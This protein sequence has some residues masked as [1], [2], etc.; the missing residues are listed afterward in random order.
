M[1]FT[2]RECFKKYCPW[3]NICETR[4]FPDQKLSSSIFPCCCPS[5]RPTS[6]ASPLI[7]TI[8]YFR[9]YKPFL[10]YFF[11]RISGIPPLT[12]KIEFW[13]VLQF[14]SSNASSTDL[15]HRWTSCEQ[16]CEHC[17]QFSTGLSH[18]VSHQQRLFAEATRASGLPNMVSPQLPNVRSWFLMPALI[19]LWFNTKAR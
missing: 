4:R 14:I 10:T 16:E 19:N 13:L 8:W 6:V 11:W 3:G 12:D 1:I 2:P 5:V 15:V 9:P 18:A 7:S 17:G